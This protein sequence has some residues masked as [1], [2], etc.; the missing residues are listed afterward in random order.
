MPK[1]GIK[2]S[3]TR[4]TKGAH[5]TLRSI[6]LKLPTFKDKPAV[7]TRWEVAVEHAQRPATAVRKKIQKKKLQ[8]AWRYRF[9]LYLC[10]VINFELLKIRKYKQLKIYS[11]DKEIQMPRLRLYS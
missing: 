7:R 10:T 5:I 6:V 9:F 11:Y 2:I 1:A 8:K 4:P 3:Q